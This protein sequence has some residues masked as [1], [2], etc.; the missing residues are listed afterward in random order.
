MAKSD[1]CKY[2]CMI[3]SPVK[4]IIYHQGGQNSYFERTVFKK[5]LTQ[6]LVKQCLKRMA[7]WLLRYFQQVEKIVSGKNCLFRGEINKSN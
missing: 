3:L 1:V 5:N 7:A 2:T 6:H 4:N